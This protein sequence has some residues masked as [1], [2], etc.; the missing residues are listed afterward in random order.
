MHILWILESNLG[1]K[2]LNFLT[3]SLNDLILHSYFQT[4]QL[5]YQPYICVVST[6]Y[7]ENHEFSGSGHII[8]SLYTEAELGFPFRICTIISELG[9]PYRNLYLFIGITVSLGQGYYNSPP[10]LRI[11][12]SKFLYR[13]PVFSIPNSFH[14]CNP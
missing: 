6:Y 10:L 8:E 9:F 12:S 14:T 3:D 5:Q 4:S 11:S 2:P 13:Y 7:T 1:F